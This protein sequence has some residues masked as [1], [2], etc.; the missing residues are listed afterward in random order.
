ML[1]NMRASFVV[2]VIDTFPPFTEQKEYESGTLPMVTI[3]EVAQ[4]GYKLCVSFRELLSL[5]RSIHA[6]AL[7]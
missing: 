3:N 7:G 5:P 6:Q 2:D 1:S 4:E